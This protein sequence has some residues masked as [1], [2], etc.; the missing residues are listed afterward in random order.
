MTARR[1]KVEAS[2]AERGRPAMWATEQEAAVLSGYSLERLNME[3]GSQV[4][5]PRMICNLRQG[6]GNSG[7]LRAG[8]APIPRNILWT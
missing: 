6:N 3:S 7:H 4:R 1:G 5:R 8:L 2:L